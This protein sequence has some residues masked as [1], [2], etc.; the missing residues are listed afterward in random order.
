VKN[1]IAPVRQ[2]RNTVD[3]TVQKI[4]SR[5]VTGDFAEGRILPKETELSAEYAIGRSTLREAVK[6][7]SGKGLVQTARRYG[8]QVCPRAT[9]NFLDPDVLAWYASV[10]ENVPDLLLSIIEFRSAIEPT[11]AE[12]AARRASREEADAIRGHA[13]ALMNVLPGEP[14]EFDIAFHVALLQ[15][16][17]N[18]LLVSL[19]PTYA[20]LL[21][22]QFRT[23][24]SIMDKN[25]TY[26]PDERHIHLADAVLARDAAKASRVAREM[27]RISRQNVESVTRS[28]GLLR[29]APSDEL[30]AAL[31]VA[32]GPRRRQA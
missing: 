18:L 2:A 6:V 24:W 5:I 4:G 29:R 32:V 25:P 9:W 20:T 30:R 13:Q 21:R 7:L 15:A 3:A 27:M 26:F 14:V 31:S 8:T 17:Q 12:L 11:I 16:T 28:L 23:S 22:A 10:P 1:V 19:V